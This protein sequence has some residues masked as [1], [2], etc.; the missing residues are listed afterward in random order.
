MIELEQSKYHSQ[1]MVLLDVLRSIEHEMNGLIKEKSSNDVSVTSVEFMIGSNKGEEQT[2]GEDE[3]LFV[4]PLK[5]IGEGLQFSLFV[6][7]ERIEL[8]T[9]EVMCI[10]ASSVRWESNEIVEVLE[11]KMLPTRQF[12]EKVTD[13]LHVVLDTN[14]DE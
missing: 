1:L 5:Q 6:K 13:V 14:Y 12:D 10:H 8:E 3:Y 11:V 2:V 4:I 9:N 7:E